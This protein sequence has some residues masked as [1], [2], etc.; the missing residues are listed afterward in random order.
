M[1]T[2]AEAVRALNDLDGGPE[3]DHRDADKILLQVPRR[4]WPW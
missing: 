4:W 1:L 2:P 3:A